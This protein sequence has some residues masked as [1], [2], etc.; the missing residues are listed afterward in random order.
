MNKEYQEYEKKATNNY[1]PLTVVIAMRNAILEWGRNN[2]RKF[3]WRETDDPYRIII[4]EIFLQRTAVKQVVPVYNQFIEKYPDISSFSG[5]RVSEIAGII[6]PLGL[7]WRAEKLI[8]IREYICNKLKGNISPALEDMLKIPGVSSYIA[9]AV[10][11]SAFNCTDA[12]L[13]TNTIRI[14]GRVFGLKMQDSSRRSVLFRHGLSLLVHPDY[15]KKSFY[16]LIDLAHLICRKKS[17]ECIKCP[18]DELCIYSLNTDGNKS[19]S[20]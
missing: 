16:S 6:S 11:V 18:L 2:I 9:G 8:E 19:D 7:K 20:G 5:A 4:A 14:T 1:P 12:P 17:P 15:P 10:R 13:D 3:P